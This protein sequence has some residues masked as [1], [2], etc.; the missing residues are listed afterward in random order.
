MVD[1]S[2]CASCDYNQ[3]RYG[4]KRPMDWVWRGEYSPA[5]KGEYER[6]KDQLA[7]ERLSSSNVDEEAF[8]SMSERQQASEVAARLKK[9]ATKAYKKTKVTQEESRTNIVCM[10]ENDFYV[11]TVREFR[12]RRYEYKKL[13]KQ[14]KGRVAAA[15]DATTRKE[16]EDK[17][18]VY[19]S[20]QIA[21]KCILNS[22]YG[23]VMR[24]GARWRS[25]EMAGVVTKLGADIIT[26]ARKLVEQIGR[27]LE[28]D[29]DGIWCILP[30]SF[31]EN[32]NL[33]TK[34]GTK[35]KLEY[36]CAMLNAD[37]HDK[38]TN[39]QYQTLVDPER[40][41]YKTR[42]ECSIYFEVDGP[43]RAMILPASTEEGKL[44]KKR[45]AVFN[46][47]GSLA[48]LKGFELKRRGE[49]ELIKTFQS[50][51]FE[52][53]L[54]GNSLKECYDAVADVANHWIDVLDTRGESLTDDELVDLISENRSM[55]RQ[56]ED[57]G[58]QKGTSQTT[59][60]RLGEFLGME[61]IKDKGLNCKFIIAEQPYGAPITDRAI[62]TN[63]WKTEP[64]VMKHF[65]RK[66]L[67]SPGLDGD[68]FDIRNILDWDYY[69]DRFSNTV[70]KIITIP[71]AL[72]RISNPVPRVEHPS[73]L[74]SKVAQFNDPFQQ[75]S[76]RD[77]F[78]SKPVRSI[79]DIEDVGG[80]ASGKSSSYSSA[81]SR[82]VRSRPVIQD[83]QPKGPRIK[84]SGDNFDS[85]LKQKKGV[86]RKAR[87]ERNDAVRGDTGAIAKRQRK[88]VN[89]ESFVRDAAKTLAEKEWHI[90]E[91]REMTGYDSTTQSQRQG[92]GEF[93]VWAIIGGESLQKVYVTVPRTVYISC[94]IQ[95]EADMAFFQ[96]FRQVDRHLPHNK[97]AKYVYEVT[98]PEHVF[99]AN[100]WL[101]KIKPKSATDVGSQVFESIYESSTPLSGRI[102]SQLGAVVRLTPKAATG[103]FRKK[104]NIE[105]LSRMEKP[106]DG[107]Y[108]NKLL[109]Y[110]RVFIYTRIHQST[111]TGV[112]VLYTMER[113]S[114]SFRVK[115]GD[116]EDLVD[117][118][119][120]RPFQSE[121]GC[122]DVAAHCHIWIV[123]PGSKG[124]SQRAQTQRNISAK[125]C[126][127]LFSQLLGTIHESAGDESDYACISSGSKLKLT[128][129]KFENDEAIAYSGANDVISTFTKAGT[130]ATVLLVNSSKPTSQLRRHFTTFS[131]HPVVSMPFPPG[132]S[133]NPKFS[134]LPALNWEQ[135]AVQ[136]SLEAYLFMSV[137]SFPKRVSYARYGHI[138]LGNLGHD[139]N[140]V[141]FDVGMMRMIEK[142][143]AVSWASTMPGRPDLGV[144]HMP[145]SEGGQFPL[146]DGELNSFT[147]DDVWGDDNEL[148]SPVIRKPGTYRSI[149][150]DVDIQDL[151]IAALTDAPDTPTS[152]GS[153]GPSSPA[154]VAG[155]PAS[156]FGKISVPLGDEMATSI[157]LPMLRSLVG[158]WLRDAFNS[159]SLVADELLHHVYRLVSSPEA[160]LHDP[161][162]H[163]IVHS[164]MKSAFLR[165]LAELQ[166]LGCTVV[167]ASFHRITVATNKLQ[168]ADAEE[169]INFV[170]TTARNRAAAESEHGD[171]L[172]KITLRPRQFHGDFVFLDEY[173]FGTMLLERVPLDSVD[174]EG[175]V[176]LQRDDTAAVVAT[177][178][179]AWSMMDYFGSEMAQEY[180]RIIM[181]RFSKDP[182]KKQIALTE[183]YEGLPIAGTGESDNQLVEYRKK[184]I[185]KNFASYLTRAVSEI[186]KDGFDE[187]TIPRHISSHFKPVSPVLEFIKSVS[188][189]LELDADVDAQVQV[190]KRSLLAQIGVAEYSKHAQWKNPA[191][192]LILPD[193]FCVECHERRDLNLF[194]LPPHDVDE[195]VDG[196]WSCEDCGAYY[197]VGSIER[198]LIGL[199]HRKSLRYQLQ[200]TRCC[201]TRRVSTRVL[202]ATTE[203]SSGLVLDATESELRGELGLLHSLAKF[204]EL[205]H[206]EDLTES[207]LRNHR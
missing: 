110:R 88:N 37:V 139:E 101:E 189:V 23:Y 33:Y 187:S 152:L 43:Y 156:D 73:W 103:K 76:I 67:K 198:R 112:V 135:P 83:E 137:V 168:L 141:L 85:W 155:F 143:L 197:D 159:N 193:V 80:N 60:R 129:L 54:D 201:K 19:D 178:L 153:V 64:H 180:F 136:L 100:Q 173:N 51:V 18:V 86:W 2:T 114:G 56:L 174:D 200:D 175:D 107:E 9:Y 48:E 171:A 167:H 186:A 87:K 13:N 27:P 183:S 24:K 150:V 121:K 162:L 66:W 140:T 195:R 104:F 36:P 89:L 84:L 118:D 192:S 111:K 8:V 50:Q 119:P 154:S 91:I 132:P 191:P 45:Y 49:L 176:V 82:H 10:R 166:R 131:S 26:Q 72:Q 29:T 163:R 194:Y 144:K 164:L 61:Y 92:F 20:L 77:M 34:D 4:C 63:I 65:L 133:H 148:V 90:L 102:L 157:S 122:F 196:R 125:Q 207:L 179:S 203:S 134:T 116:A 7:R 17:V 14:W 177:V 151:A 115:D 59:A 94:F 75:K 78:K 28:L 39:H 35:L 42:S 96:D 109:S 55:S 69:M 3:S 206:L 32:Y 165:L 105:E 108:L 185:S 47:D 146:S 127:S 98:M 99:R 46:F 181:G 113:G 130:G 71:A 169:F 123:K 182:M 68:G 172:S 22:F 95:V 1:D 149:C 12:D 199:A 142:N 52:R 202:T 204:H 79:A 93:V 58:D 81:V 188:T 21:H 30:H 97:S 138:P 11:D 70:R 126:D 145:T 74:L 170:I 16:C 40:G 44:L 190:L 25:M 161:A 38:F 6:T 106:N 117:E 205:P 128:S 41:T 5:T 15:Q 53:F 62:P 31:P 147:Q 184:M 160:F 57:Y 158:V 120:T 124:K